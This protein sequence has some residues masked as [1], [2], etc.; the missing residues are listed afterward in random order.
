MASEIRKFYEFGK[1]RFDAQKLRLEHDGET[2]QLP[3]KSLET[4][5]VLLEEKGEIITRESFLGRIWA[6]NFVEDANLTVAIS[7]LRKTLAAYEKEQNF[8]QTVPR[9]GYRFIGDAQ[10]VT[11]IS[12]Q[13]IVV[14]R[15][16][17]E[18]LTVE[19]TLPK[20][21]S[22][23]FIAIVLVVL[24]SGGAAIAFWF[25]GGESVFSAKNGN[26][27]ADEAFRKG[28]ALLQKR[29]TVCDSISYFREAIAKDETHARAHA[30]LAA[31]LAMCN[32]P[33]KEADALVSRALALDPN[34][35]DAHATD[36]FIKMFV[37]WDWNGAEAALRRAV[38]LD[39]NSAKAHHWLGVALSIRGRFLEARGEMARAIEIAPDSPLYRADLCQILY[40]EPNV[41]LAITECRKALELDPNFL[42]TSQYL[43]DVYLLMGDEQKA[44]EYE[45]KY[46][47]IRQNPPEAIKAAEEIFKREG[48]KGLYKV[49]IRSHL[50]QLK[51]GN[52]NAK[53]RHYH[54]LALAEN[55]TL[56]GDRENALNWLEQ[57]FDG[58]RRAYPFWAAY[59]GVDPRNAFLRD[60]PRFQAVL[61]KMNLAD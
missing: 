61:R 48:F 15:H 3:P 20:T 24:I 37:H 13:P 17:V 52:A 58:E 16:A 8:I 28:E 49:G 5:K 27:A 31:A 4:L 30:N 19:E 14:V 42:F 23:S 51:N 50:E 40:F 10:E 18:S 56:L 2:V 35:A 29:L 45:V 36:G 41:T 46:L 9:Q 34:S 60:D 43:R 54:T 39:P 57:S 53:N 1:F 25:G 22:R 6:E 21:F 7:T 44:W 32:D 47:L 11:E 12:E 26:P 55:Y 38:L 33:E 59:I